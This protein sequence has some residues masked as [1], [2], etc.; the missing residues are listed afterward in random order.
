M[1]K[2]DQDRWIIAAN[3][4]GTKIPSRIYVNRDVYIEYNLENE[5]NNI[6]NVP[7]IIRRDSSDYDLTINI[8]GKQLT[9]PLKHIRYIVEDDIHKA[10]LIEKGLGAGCLVN[11]YEHILNLN[12]LPIEGITTETLVQER[13]VIVSKHLENKAK[14][15]KFFREQA[16]EYIN[17]VV[18]K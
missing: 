7:F 15:V 8:D 11:K 5:P 13:T 12:I 2:I 10:K 3:I 4:D 14:L 16:A 17:T 18:G 6:F 1:E 9:P